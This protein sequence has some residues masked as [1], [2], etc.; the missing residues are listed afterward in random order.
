MSGGTKSSQAQP[1][2]ELGGIA[3]E[4]GREPEVL[5]QC[6]GRGPPHPAHLAHTPSFSGEFTTPQNKE[7]EEEEE[8]EEE[9]EEEDEED[10]E[11][12]GK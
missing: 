2:A 12:E 11:E 10:E 3:R 6:F 8:K 4:S 9:E 7:S 1:N 5:L